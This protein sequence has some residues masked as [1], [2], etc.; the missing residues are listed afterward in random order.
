MPDLAAMRA[1]LSRL[2]LSAILFAMR[3]ALGFTFFRAGLL[4]WQSFEFAVQLFTD[5]YGLP[6]LPPELAARLAMMV[7]LGVPPFLVLGLGTRLATLPLLAMTLVIVGLV[8]PAAWPETLLWASALALILTRGPG[9]LS[10]DH[11]LSQAKAR[12]AL[13]VGSEG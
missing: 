12:K 2:P 7:E 6:L 4:K 8:Y 10:I 5:E 13:A 11:V 1:W 3:L 9:R